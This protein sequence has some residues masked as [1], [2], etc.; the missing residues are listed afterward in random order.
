MIAKYPRLRVILI[1]LL[2]LEAFLPSG[3]SARETTVPIQRLQLTQER[4]AVNGVLVSRPAAIDEK[5]LAL[6]RQNQFQSVND[7]AGWLKENTEY[8]A[9]APSTDWP[10]PGELLTNRRGDCKDFAGLNARVLKVLGYQPRVLA[11]TTRTTG[12]AICVFEYAGKFYW[13]DNAELKGSSA[14]TLAELSVELTK[15]FHYSRVLEVDL[16]TRQTSLVHQ[17]PA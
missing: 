9:E 4:T 13:F 12:H 1:L 15:E 14:R 16:S 10:E 7:Y 3:L 6:I 11:M 8:R 5:I 2:G 17:N